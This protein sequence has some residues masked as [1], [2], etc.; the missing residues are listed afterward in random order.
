[1]WKMVPMLPPVLE[2]SRGSLTS[3]LSPSHR[4]FSPE[5]GSDGRLER[6]NHSLLRNVEVDYNVSV[7]ASYL[8]RQ[9][10]DVL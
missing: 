3:P 5:S 1:M 10:H 2:F 9:S 8:T 7:V 6:I 4:A